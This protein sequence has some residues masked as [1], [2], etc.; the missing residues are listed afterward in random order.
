MNFFITEKMKMNDP[1]QLPIND[2]FKT[3]EF[4]ILC[5]TSDVWIARK[6]V[7]EILSQIQTHFQDDDTLIIFLFDKIL[8]VDLKAEP[9]KYG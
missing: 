2:F 9:V 8:V 7:E 4:D 3:T 1:I 5:R 6:K